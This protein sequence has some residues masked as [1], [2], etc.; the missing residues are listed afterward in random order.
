MKKLISLILLLTAC[1]K[2]DKD[3]VLERYK[4]G[5]CGTF[6]SSDIRAEE[7]KKHV[8]EIV[9]FGEYT[10]KAKEISNSKIS[11]IGYDKFIY[12]ERDWHQFIPLDCPKKECK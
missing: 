9:N 1:A 2:T 5:Q 8:V 6:T 4:I 7:A 11:E 3:L 10:V 12:N